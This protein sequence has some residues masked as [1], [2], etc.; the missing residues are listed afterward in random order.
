MSRSGLIVPPPCRP[1]AAPR[2]IGPYRLTAEIASGRRTQVYLG[3][4]ED[5]HRPCLIRELSPAQD[6]RGFQR[7]VNRAIAFQ[8]GPGPLR[9]EEHGK[10]TILVAPPIV[11][12]S[13]A[14]VLDR[15]LG[16]EHPLPIDLSLA[17]TMG[18]AARLGKG[19][20]R[21]IHGDLAPHHVI[22]G[23]DG[24]VSLIDPAGPE[25][26]EERAK[27]PGREGYRSPEHV[28]HEG[29]SP[30]S[31]VFVL[32]VLLFELTTGT[33]LYPGNTAKEAEALILE[34]GYPRPRAV[35]GDHYPIELQVLLRKLLRAQPEARYFDGEAALE[36]LRLAGSGQNAE[37]TQRLGEWLR[38]SFRD[39]YRAWGVV[40]AE[41]GIELPEV[42]VENDADPT[43]A[44]DADLAALSQAKPT[45]MPVIQG[46]PKSALPAPSGP[47][48][49][50]L[51]SAAG[52][53]TATLRDAPRVPRNALFRPLEETDPDE[54]TRPELEPPP[55]SPERAKTKTDKPPPPPPPPPPAPRERERT[56]VDSH[57]L[58][59]EELTPNPGTPARGATLLDA[60]PPFLGPPPPREPAKDEP[61]WIDEA[62]ADARAQPTEDPFSRASTA[63]DTRLPP[64]L[65][66]KPDEPPTIDS[67]AESD[68]QKEID[69]AKSGETVDDHAQMDALGN[70]PGLDVLEDLRRAAKAALEMPPGELDPFAER[71]ERDRPF[72]PKL[73]RALVSARIEEKARRLSADL[74]DGIKAGGEEEGPAV[75]DDAS[76]DLVPG[77]EELTPAPALT[78]APTLAQAKRLPFDLAS[79]LIADTAPPGNDTLRPPAP[80]PGQ[81][82]PLPRTSDAAIPGPRKVRTRSDSMMAG[83]E[84]AT[85]ADEAF[86]QP[87]QTH[88]GLPPP[89]PPEAAETQEMQAPRPKKP[90]PSAVV[91]SSDFDLEKKPPEIRRE[92]TMVVRQRVIPRDTVKHEVELLLPAGPKSLGLDDPTESSATIPRPIDP[93]RDD[94]EDTDS[95]V[96][97][98][99]PVSEEEPKKKAKSGPSLWP[100]IAILVALIAAGLGVIWYLTSEGAQPPRVVVPAP[101]VETPPSPEPKAIAAS[102]A[103]AATSTEAPVNAVKSATKAATPEVETIEPEPEPE[104]SPSPKEEAAEPSPSSTPAPTRPPVRES[105]SPRA[106]AAAA[107][108]RHPVA[109]K[110]VVEIKVNVFPVSAH[111][112]IDDIEIENG[113]KVLLQGEPLT[114]RASAEGYVEQRVVL[115][116]SGKKEV[117]IVLRPKR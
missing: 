5:D 8:G 41:H 70:L 109:G 71:L 19:G 17:I 11:G 6:A 103:P 60:R 25:E 89:R 105:P 96:E 44:P 97:L 2:R 91:P 27:A 95:E 59:S 72:E 10:T 35:I 58:G 14:T 100:L 92:A 67:A 78:P 76:F 50:A 26:A 43:E 85:L 42:D 83:S 56:R 30:A 102:P 28:R 38:A 15:V 98:V 62:A 36:G 90:A 48:P 114:V 20:P 117:A 47:P 86:K 110:P 73:D 77:S 54:S 88:R 93:R 115:K 7:E 68:W 18:I 55:T 84:A 31:D 16:A 63:L 40:L 74:L 112:Y 53:A 12:E 3:V 107:H 33:R 57:P 61:T 1:L 80:A 52:S 87:R 39:R 65:A 21:H 79:D 64:A 45:T 75:L 82:T 23:Y 113:G 99:V 106:A 46:P 9:A 94:V 101:R 116:P 29:L 37:R 69:A 49:G 22:I 32:G 51:R 24:S 66:P 13:L 34:G 108:G 4:R 111:L 81:G 104:E